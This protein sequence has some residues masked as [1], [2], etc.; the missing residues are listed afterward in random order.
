MKID[1][2]KIKSSYFLKMKLYIFLCTNRCDIE[3]SSKKC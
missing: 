1:L 3:L 2:I